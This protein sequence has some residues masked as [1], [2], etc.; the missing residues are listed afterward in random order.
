MT[1]RFIRT[2]IIIGAVTALVPGV[3]LGDEL[4]KKGSTSYTTNFVFHPMAF[5][6]LKDDDRLVGRVI[7]LQLFGKTTNTKGEAAFDKMDVKCFAIKVETGS[8]SDFNGACTMEDDDHDK[9][10]S[11]FDSRELDKSQPE[12]DCGTHFIVGGTGKYKGITGTEP[13]SCI[14]KGAIK[15]GEAFGDYRVE[16]P[17]NVT[18]EIK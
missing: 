12:M 2:A 15:A 14:F 4:A 10:F 11:T 7:P 3:V 1:H 16:I 6:T 9:I 5:N 18:W 13:F 8:K 17:H